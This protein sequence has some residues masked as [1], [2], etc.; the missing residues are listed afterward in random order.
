MVGLDNI[1]EKGNGKGGFLLDLLVDSKIGETEK[2][3]Y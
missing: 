1:I 2:G 3:A